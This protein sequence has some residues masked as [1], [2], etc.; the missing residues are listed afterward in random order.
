MTCDG[1]GGFVNVVKTSLDG[2]KAE[3]TLVVANRRVAVLV[4][5]NLMVER[6]AI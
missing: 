6:F 1:G 4:S 5:I 2:E 3:T